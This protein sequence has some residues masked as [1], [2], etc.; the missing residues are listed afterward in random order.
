MVSTE[1]IRKGELAKEAAYQIGLVSTELK[2]KALVKMA[3]DLEK[4]TASVLAA[5][6][7]DMEKAREK[8]YTQAFL[9]RL[10]LTEKRVKEMAEGLKAI[11]RLSDPVG[12][13]E[14]MWTTTD[15]LQIGKMRVPLGVIGIIYEAR[16]NVTADAAGLC[17]KA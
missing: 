5:N 17:L 10:S 8:K 4:N 9:D 14:R 2:N 11:A 16:P 6:N 13:V 1:L 3:E 15:G 12:E 7:L